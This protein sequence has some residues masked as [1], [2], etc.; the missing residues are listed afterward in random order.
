MSTEKSDFSTQS[1]ELRYVEGEVCVYATE[2]GLCSIIAVCKKLIENHKIG[3][4]H[5]EDYDLLTPN[6]LKGV[7]A[8]FTPETKTGTDEEV[9]DDY[10]KCC[11]KTDKTP[12]TLYTENFVLRLDPSLHAHLSAKAKATGKSLDQFATEVLFHAN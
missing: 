6:S 11:T 10:L 12:N 2:H 4:V 8:V 5:L 3:H 7:I 9:V 1:I